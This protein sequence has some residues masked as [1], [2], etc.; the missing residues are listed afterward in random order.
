MRINILRALILIVLPMLLFCGWTADSDTSVLLQAPE[1]GGIVYTMTP[2]F[3]WSAA[4]AN[5]NFT[6]QIALDRTFQELVVNATSIPGFTYEVPP[7][8]LNRSSYYWRVGQGPTGRIVSWSTTWSFVVSQSAQATV[9]VNA[10][11]DGQAWP[12]NVDCTV[13]GM[14][15]TAPCSMVPEQYAPCPAGSYTLIYNGYGPQGATLSGISPASTQNLSE[16]GTIYFTLDFT[17]AQQQQGSISIY[18]TLDGSPLATGINVSLSGPYSETV[19]NVPTSRYNLPTGTY[20]VGY[21][22]GGPNSATLSSIYPGT[23]QYL[24]NGSSI[25]FTIKLRTGMGSTGGNYP[26]PVVTPYNQSYSKP[27]PPPPQVQPV[28]VNPVYAPPVSTM[29]VGASQPRPM[30]PAV[31]PVQPMPTGG[32]AGMR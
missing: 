17:R 12:G 28:T 24:G 29:P 10:T 5:Q 3:T 25:S 2:I 14:G 13:V 16:G 11:L 26:P 18:T 21:N 23:S 20:Y 9:G 8:K 6:L 30:P 27:V 4:D 19:Y 15:I 7:G 22:Y 1:S 31:Q 32:G